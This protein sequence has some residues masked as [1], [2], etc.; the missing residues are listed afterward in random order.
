MLSAAKRMFSFAGLVRSFLLL[1]FVIQA[2]CIAEG[3]SSGGSSS[4]GTVTSAFSGSVGDG[5]IVGATLKFRDRDGNLIHTAESDQYAK[6]AT[7]LTADRSAYP[8]TVEVEGGIDLVTGREAD[9]KLTSVI[10]DPANDNININPYTTMITETARSMPS[11]LTKSNIASARDIVM[12]EMNFGLDS[13][14][15]NDP[16]KTRIHDDNVVNITKSSEA[17]G[18]MIRRVRASLSGTGAV[19]N[20]DDVV[21]TIATDLADGAFDGKAVADTTRRT[22]ASSLSDRIAERIRK[23]RV[24]AMARITAAQVLIE[25]MTNSL[26]VDGKVATS[27]LDQSITQTNPTIESSKLTDGVVNNKKVL[28]QTRESVDATRNIAPSRELTTISEVLTTIPDETLP[29][30]VVRKL[31]PDSSTDFDDAIAVATVATEDQLELVNK[32][33]RE[34]NGEAN[35]DGRETGDERDSDRGSDAK[36]EQRSESGDD[37]PVVNEDGND[38]GDA[39]ENEDDFGNEDQTASNSESGIEN[40]SGNQDETSSEGES[41]NEGESSNERE[42]GNTGGSAGSSE[43]ASGGPSDAGEDAPVDNTQNTTTAPANQAPV[44]SGNP[45]QS[46]TS[47]NSYMFQPNA[48]DADGDSL[49]FSIRNKPSWAGF[50]TNSG[51]LSGTPSASDAGKSFK[52]ITITVTD[53]K[54]SVTLPAFSVTVNATASATPK[55]GSVSLSWTAPSTRSDGKNLSLSEISGYTVYYGNKAGSYPNAIDINNPATTSTTIKD[56]PSGTYYMVMTTRDTAGQES[57]KSNM[58]T[59][60]AQ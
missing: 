23:K 12:D 21:R 54:A 9:F 50:S 1:S 3:D 42:S 33:S 2:G 13:T 10:D 6:Y 43:S 52:N 53:G 38:D 19:N 56:L 30:D 60:T 14:L 57:A 45:A 41:G 4:S 15:V 40:D 36:D 18:E 27:A 51:R 34:S 44:I 47:G 17:M 24:A 7:E 5:P 55:S 35:N 32:S 16:I 29:E 58:V 11:G 37:N 49:K 8:L 59:K 26:R 31:P 39:R 25:S 48:S 20:E 22:A 28:D 46:V